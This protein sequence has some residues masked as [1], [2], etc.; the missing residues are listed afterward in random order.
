MQFPNDKQRMVILGAT[1]SGKTVAGLWFLSQRNYDTKPWV[2]YDFKGEALINS[3]K[4]A[5]RL[6]VGSKI[7]EQPGLYVVNPYP[8]QEQEVEA[9]MWGI[10][11]QEN[12][13]VFIDE[14]FMVGNKNRAFRSLLTQGRSKHIPMIILSQRPV[15]LDRFV[16]S[17]SEFFQVFRLQHRKDLASVQEF[18]PFDLSTRLPEHHSYY[19]SVVDNSCVI[20]KPTPSDDVILDNFDAK[21]SRLTRTV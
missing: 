7:P 17:E 13:G 8:D 19:Y 10:W 3:I 12:I 4:G 6:D 15:W 16:F 18:V 5:T 11:Q 2:I 14:G 21:L 1:G 20:L 9:Q